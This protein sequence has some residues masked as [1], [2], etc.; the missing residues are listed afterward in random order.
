M[1]H[2]QTVAQRLWRRI[3][4]WLGIVSVASCSVP[5]STPVEPT[6]R[7]ATPP[8]PAAAPIKKPEA[9]IVG[10]QP[11][12]RTAADLRRHAAQRLVAAN[13]GRVYLGKPPDPLLAIP[14]LEVELLPDGSI[15]RI[16][17]LRRP[18][19][20]QDTIQLAIDAV[21]RAAPFGDLRHMHEARRF[22]ETFLF[23]D[24]RRFKPRTLD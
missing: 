6:P 22:T 9:S 12:I 2:T 21:K 4:T 7:P 14:V 17:I 18:S 19:Q 16:E 5:S 8:A 10:A 23:D 20:A 15:R 13:P 3:G 24:D 11:I 1:T